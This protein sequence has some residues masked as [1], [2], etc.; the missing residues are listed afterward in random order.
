MIITIG[1][2]KGGQGKS[3]LSVNLALMRSQSSAVLLVDAD[4]QKSSLRFAQQRQAL[5]L[6]T[7]WTTIALNGA[8]VR[9]E[10][11]KLKTSYETTLIDTGGRDTN[12]LRAALSISDIFLVPFQ[13]RA[14]DI[15]TLNEIATLVE[16]AKL[17][18]DSL[19][20]Y[21]FINCGFTRGSDND[22]AQ[23]ILAKNKIIELLPVTISMRKS[24]SNA[25]AEGKGVIELNND[26]KAV[27]EI[28]ELYYNIYKGE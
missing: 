19:K 25:A 17:I 27:S 18:N 9:S 1:S 16:E 4:E 23:A 14:F 11:N 10:V 8:S 20:A 28:L 24:F 2:I 6:E 15:W 13:P 26:P 5:G 12:S 22:E 21:C 3:T 7:N